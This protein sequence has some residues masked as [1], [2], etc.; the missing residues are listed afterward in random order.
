MKKYKIKIEGLKKT[1]IDIEAENENDAR[2]KLEI[3]LGNKGLKALKFDKMFDSIVVKD[4]E[5]TE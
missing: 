1:S 5:E 3:L 2:I 4:I